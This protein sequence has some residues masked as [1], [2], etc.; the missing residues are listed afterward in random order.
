MADA[1]APSTE[2]TPWIVCLDLQD[3][4]SAAPPADLS[5]RIATCR[6]LL[7]QAR[8][9]GWPLIHV[10]RGQGHAL[11]AARGSRP[12]PIEGLQ[13]RPFETVI[14]RAGLSAFSD[15]T[16]RALIKGGARREIVLV[17][18]ALGPACLATVLDAHDRGVRLTLVEDTL[19]AKAMRR[20][21][22]GTV[23]RVLLAFVAPF[24]GRTTSGRLF[25]TGPMRPPAAN[26][27]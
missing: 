26:D 14:F 8:R 16:F 19:C 20:T 27:S 25:E 23:R 5:R 21:P 13:P 3:E 15:R 7:A 6:R 18:V 4:K 11:E 2:Q 1:L 24:A 22:A 10:L 9:L 12:P 17:A